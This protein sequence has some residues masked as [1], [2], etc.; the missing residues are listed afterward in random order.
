MAGRSFLGIPLA[1]PP[2]IPPPIR[3]LLEP[4][5][6]F[7]NLPEFCQGYVL[8]QDYFPVPPKNSVFTRQAI[9]P[10][11]GSGGEPRQYLLT[12]LVVLETPPGI[13]PLIF[14]GDSYY[15]TRRSSRTYQVA[16][17]WQYL[18]LTVSISEF[19]SAK[20]IAVSGHIF[21]AQEQLTDSNKVLY[22]AH[23]PMVS[24]D[25]GYVCLGTHSHVDPYVHL[26]VA[27]QDILWAFYHN[28]AFFQAEPIPGKY[29]TLEKWE[30]ASKDPNC[31]KTWVNARRTHDRKS[32]ISLATGWAGD[33][34][35]N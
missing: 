24:L 34:F 25:S 3:E 13:H 29:G 22:S 18:L 12:T 7:A 19:R 20:S 23:L 9:K 11:G 16:M 28:S 21:W 33:A 15:S 6:D 10:Y 31:W 4:P 2:V 32:A 17:P 27:L 5:K 35:G 30:E 1:P 8:G 14:V 26:N